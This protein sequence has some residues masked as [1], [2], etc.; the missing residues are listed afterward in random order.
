MKLL[1][2]EA[3][4][5]FQLVIESIKSGKEQYFILAFAHVFLSICLIASNQSPSLAI[6]YLFLVFFIYTVG[7]IKV[8]QLL[9][10]NQSVKLAD[11][12]YAFKNTSLLKKM[13]LSTIPLFLDVMGAVFSLVF[14]SII[15]YALFVGNFFA[16]WTAMMGGQSPQSGVLPLI[17]SDISKWCARFFVFLV[18]PL[19]YLYPCFL[20]LTDSSWKQSLILSVKSTLKNPI[21]YL[22][23]VALNLPTAIIQMLM[24]NVQGDVTTA[25]NI[26]LAVGFVGAFFVPFYISL[27]YRFFKNIVTD[28]EIKKLI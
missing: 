3:Q 15:I 21:F 22:I 10:E 4:P 24:M 7:L 13:T 17:F 14:I 25:Q 20:L 12:L 16:D 2:V 26:T 23:Q 19:F 6:I 11:F 28:Y 9:E 1:R 27:N 18:T 8:A 5:S